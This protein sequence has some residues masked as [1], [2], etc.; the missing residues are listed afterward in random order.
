MMCTL[1]TIGGTVVVNR[2]MLR[3]KY[4]KE[5]RHYITAIDDKNICCRY[6]VTPQCYKS[7]CLES[8]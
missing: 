6:E 8:M 3:K 5:G 7:L 4:I 2:D 1:E